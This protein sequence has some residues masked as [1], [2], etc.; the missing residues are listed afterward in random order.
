MIYSLWFGER[1]TSL[2]RPLSS[3]AAGQKT[4]YVIPSKLIAQPK[5]TIG[6]IKTGVANDD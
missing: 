2:Y 3:T 6:N 4:F 5:L 1:N